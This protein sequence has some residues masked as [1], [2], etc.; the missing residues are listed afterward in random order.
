M[1]VSVRHPAG[2]LPRFSFAVL[3]NIDSAADILIS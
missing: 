1:P 3:P 2:F